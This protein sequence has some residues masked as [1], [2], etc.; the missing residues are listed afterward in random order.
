[1]AKSKGSKK[2]GSKDSKKG[3]KKSKGSAPPTPPPSPPVKPRIVCCPTG[4]CAACHFNKCHDCFY[5]PPCPPDCRKPCCM[6]C[7][8]PMNCTPYCAPGC[9][10]TC[11]QPVP[12]SYKRFLWDYL[13]VN[14][15]HCRAVN[16]P[17]LNLSMRTFF[18][19]TG[20]HCSRRCQ[21]REVPKWLVLMDLNSQMGRFLGRILC[22]LFE[23]LWP[24]RDHLSRKPITLE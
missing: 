1:M 23:V 9:A 17:Y 3:S 21:S 5:V 12:R 7:C 10:Q 19:V 8:C 18:N 4:C 22:A 14:N 15:T 13:H 2:G 20:S 16:P 24:F 11:D 6:P